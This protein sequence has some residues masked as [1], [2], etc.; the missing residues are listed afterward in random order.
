MYPAIFVVIFIVSTDLIVT[1]VN[2]NNKF[3]ALII[4]LLRGQSGHLMIL[5][6]KRQYSITYPVDLYRKSLI[7]NH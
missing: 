3:T 7:I 5:V 2:R 4:Y 1:I 6:D